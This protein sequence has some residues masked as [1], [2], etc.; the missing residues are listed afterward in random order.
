MSKINYIEINKTK[1][2]IENVAYL[3]ALPVANA[4]SEDFVSVNNV[5][6]VKQVNNGVYSYA[7]IGGG[8]GGSNNDTYELT[9]TIDESNM[10]NLQNLAYAIEYGFT[11]TI[12]KHMTSSLFNKN[13]PYTEILI[14]SDKLPS[15]FLTEIFNKKYLNM[16]MYLPEQNITIEI[17]TLPM[18][19]YAL[20]PNDSSSKAINFGF[21][22]FNEYNEDSIKVISRVNVYIVNTDNPLYLHIEFELR[23][24]AISTTSA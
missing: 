13:F 22:Y 9:L 17:G 23:R 4:D 15:D 8:S 7:E 5:L 16:K 1:R 18:T 11:P 24:Y 20:K 21:N 3:Q 14:T 10:E 6:Y 19:S 12:A 2:F